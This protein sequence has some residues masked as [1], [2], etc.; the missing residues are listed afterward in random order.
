MALFSWASR[1]GLIALVFTLSA[2]AQSADSQNAA[3]TQT[4]PAT[5]SAPQPDLLIKNGTVL[6]VTHGVI[7]NGSVLVHNGK[8]AQVGTNISAPSG[9]TVIDATG[10]F[11]MPGVID[12]HSHLALDG[13]VNEAT[14]PI[15]PAMNML[16]AFVNT[17]KGLYQALA[18]GVTS[19]LLLHG[20]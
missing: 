10:K 15:T 11:V 13:D 14:S 4:P 20:S 16:D 1:L 9:A 7:Q 6:T 8:I 12:A 2:F 19:L 17:D 18:G 5:Q 3:A